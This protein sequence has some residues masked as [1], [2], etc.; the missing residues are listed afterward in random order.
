MTAMQFK[1]IYNHETL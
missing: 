1:I